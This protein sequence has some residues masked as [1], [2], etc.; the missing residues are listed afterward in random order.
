MHT[1]HKGGTLLPHTQNMQHTCKI[2]RDQIEIDTWLAPYPKYAPS[3]HMEWTYQYRT[4]TKTYMHRVHE[5]T[6]TQVQ[7]TQKLLEHKE[8]TYEMQKG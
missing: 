3:T 5:M 2:H 1:H 4:Y 6:C 8:C 7:N